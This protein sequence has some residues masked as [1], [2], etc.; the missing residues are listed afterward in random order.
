MWKAQE[1]GVG[2]LPIEDHGIIGNLHT[3]ALV[4]KDGTIDWLCLPAF[5][6]PS[7]FCSILD[8][9][10]GGHFALRPVEYA[11]SQQLY[12]PD[13]NVLLTR[14]F[15]PDGLA[16]TLDFMPTMTSHGERHRLVRNVRVIRGRMN[17]LVECL[18]AFDYARRSHS[19]S[20]V[21]NS[22]AVFASGDHR[23]G[24]ATDMRL[25]E[26]AKGAA[27]ARFTL[28]EGERATFVLAHLEQGE[29]PG[30]I[31]SHVRFEELLNETLRYWRRWL[32]NS[33]Y[34]GRWREMVHR[35][36]LVLKLMVYDPT[37]ALIASPTMGLP[38]R[39]GGARNWDYRYTWLRDAALTL[40]ALIYVGFEDEARNF[41]GWLRDRCQQDVDGLLQPL[42]GIDGRTD[43]TE[44]ELTHL[45]GYLNSH[46]VRLGNGAHTQRQLDL[47][48]A[49]LDA[50]YLYNK[51]GAPLDYDLWKSLQKILDWLSENWREP[52]E[53]IWEVRGGR[54]QFVSSK[55]L[56]WVA[57]ERA[58]RI[59]R[60]R[61]LPAGEGRWIVQRDEIYEEIMEKGWN[62][63]KNSFVQYYGSDALDASL[64]MMPLVKFVGPTDPRWIAT[65]QRI[66][67]ELAYDTLVDRYKTEEAAPD[68]LE[69]SEGSFSLCS[70]WLV[71]CLTQAGRLDEARLALEKMFSYANHLG[72]YAEE[73]GQSGEA[74]GNFPQAFTHLALISAA[75]HLDRALGAD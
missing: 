63:R 65:L 73:I 16:E 51:H 34:H 6:S 74:L 52:D 50:A 7:V 62:P 38:E 27:G 59:A 71:E 23:L 43:I 19:V 28:E 13:T 55:L 61:G 12:L 1:A 56:S 40:Y 58:G 37:G 46:P 21:K 60:Q 3:A 5:D 32:S 69:G 4:G 47:Y 20:V 26:N 2:Y 39:I 54:R 75:V 53:G 35:S 41:M 42:Y 57:L 67:E 36:A 30:E 49:V 25:E 44:M 29:G 10:K 18:P 45:S 70:F 66:Q 72:L 22:G 33:T 11:R 48:G 15:S 14:Y 24:L 68:G 8:D 9:E 64:L 17:F 31:L